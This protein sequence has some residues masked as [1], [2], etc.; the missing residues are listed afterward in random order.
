MF[1]IG[2]QAESAPTTS[3]TVTTPQLPCPPHWVYM[4][5]HCYYFSQKNEHNMTWHEAQAKCEQLGVS[6]GV[7]GSNLVSIHSLDENHFISK[8]YADLPAIYLP[9]GL[10]QATSE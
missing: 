6:E 5:S 7:N 10:Q 2:F 1:F 9:I 8:W 3:I 4:T